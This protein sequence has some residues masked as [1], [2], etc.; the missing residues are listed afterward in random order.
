[1]SSLRKRMLD[2][3]HLCNYSKSTIKTYISCVSGFAIYY[4]KS[5]T[6]LDLES[7]RMY[8]LYLVEERKLSASSIN[9]AY[10]GIKLLYTKILLREWNEIKLPRAKRQKTLPR[11]LSS[12]GSICYLECPVE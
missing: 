2:Y 7:V 11:V 4:G 1:M 3:M 9:A 8:L 6:L 10:N 5:P 12:G